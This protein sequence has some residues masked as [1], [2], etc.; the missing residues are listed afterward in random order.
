MASRD[1]VR[2]QLVNGRVKHRLPVTVLEDGSRNPRQVLVQTLSVAVS[3]RLEAT[4]D[5]SERVMRARVRGAVLRRR[6]QFERPLLGWQR[7][8]R[9]RSLARVADSAPGDRCRMQLGLESD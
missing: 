1:V 7:V 4:I 6:G 2:E 3:S 9:A 8:Q 5:L